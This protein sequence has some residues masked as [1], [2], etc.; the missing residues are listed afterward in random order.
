MAEPSPTPSLSPPAKRRAPTLKAVA[1]LAGVSM[2]TASAVL[3]GRSQK[4]RI[5]PATQE[6]VLEVASSLGYQAN[7]FASSLRLRRS[8]SIGVIWSFGGPHGASSLVRCF[9][10]QAMQHGYTSTVY[11]SMGDP[12]LIASQLKELARRRVDGLVIQMGGLIPQDRQRE[13]VALLEKFPNVVIVTDLEWAAPFSQIIHSR[14]VAV[15]Q[16]VAHLL[17]SGRRH[18]AFIGPSAGKKAYDVRSTISKITT[19]GIAFSDFARNEGDISR[20]LITDILSQPDAAGVD[21][22]LTSTDEVA[23]ATLHTLRASGK[24]V[25]EDVAVIGF[26][27]NPISELFEPPIASVERLDTEVA[28]LAMEQVIQSVEQGEP[29]PATVCTIPMQFIWRESAGGSPLKTPQPAP[30]PS[31]RK[32]KRKS[33]FT[34]LEL[35]VVIALVAVLAAILFPTVKAVRQRTAQAGCLNNLRQIGVAFQG[36]VHENNGLLPYNPVSGG[37]SWYMLIGPYGGFNYGEIYT[38]AEAAI[39]A[40]RIPTLARKSILHCPGE[41]TIRQPYAEYSINRELDESVSKEQAFIR[42]TALVSPAR[43]AI[44]ADSFASAKIYTDSR[45]K[46]VDWNHLT[47]RH[48]GIPNFLYGDW[49]AAPYTQT[50]EGLSDSAGKT[51]AIQALWLARFQP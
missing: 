51:P 10:Q 50:F 27:N 23:A 15:E 37:G 34:F 47:R 18:F 30:A 43:Y 39:K 49:H 1:E 45:A 24:R 48:S 17:A 2:P 22:I 4:V 12:A 46:M 16:M 29:L 6:R 5:A 9:S 3:N 14:V 44:V 40:G 32:P 26:N 33:G 20:A 31:S 8:H 25:P 13:Y 7:P 11:D 35:L 36:Y 41:E 21:A 42:Q 19:P 38:E 28:S